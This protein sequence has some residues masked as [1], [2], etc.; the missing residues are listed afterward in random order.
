MP[1]KE[2]HVFGMGNNADTQVALNQ[3][4]TALIHEVTLLEHRSTFPVPLGVTLG[5]IPANEKTDLGDGYAFTVLPH[6]KIASPQVLYKCDTGSEEGNQW[7]KEYPKYN[8]SNINTEGV[9]EVPNAPFVFVHQDHPCIALLRHNA[10]LI[11]CNIDEQPK[12]DGQFFKIAR[13]VLSA[14]CD[15]LRSQVLTKVTSNDLSMFQSQLSRLNASSWDEVD[16]PLIMQSFKADPTWDDMRVEM[17]KKAH[18]ERFISTP[19]TYM[20]R[21]QIKYEVQ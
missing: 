10:S 18:M 7:R 11:G 8:A 13:Q 17:E 9:L 15:T 19:Y 20:A 3:L 1:G 4:R 21:L 14:C 2:V 12:M 16:I 6:S 5:C